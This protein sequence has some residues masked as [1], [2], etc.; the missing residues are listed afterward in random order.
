MK[1]LIE[2]EVAMG[3]VF[4]CAVALLALFLVSGAGPN[5]SRVT[6][7][8]DITYSNREG[9]HRALMRLEQ[10]EE[11]VNGTVRGNG[12]SDG[13]IRGNIDGAKFEF[14]VRFYDSG[15]R[16]GSPTA[17]K[18][19]LEASS[20]KGFCREHAQDWVAKRR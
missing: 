12:L 14:E 16:L 11:K 9:S 10:N 4:S 19:T 15:R 20:M 13:V 17:C 2:G 3:N 1:R 6:G 8:W 7:D 5:P 18:A